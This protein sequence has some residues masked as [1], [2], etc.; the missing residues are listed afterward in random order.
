MKI[1]IPNFIRWYPVTSILLSG[2]LIAFSI[3]TYNYLNINYFNVETHIPV[4]VSGVHH[5]GSE[6]LISHFSVNK[7]IGDNISRS[8]SSGIVCC[9]MIPKKWSPGLTA[10]V[11]W[12]VLHVI[13]QPDGIQVA[14]EELV[15]IYRAQV[16]V[17]AYSEGDRFWVHFFPEGRVRIVVNS[18]APEAEQHPIRWGDPDAS[19]KATVGA[20]V[21]TF[22]TAEE[23]ADL[24][25]RIE[26]DKKKYGDWR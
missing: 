2:I 22:Y 5:M 18:F 16:P 6:Y 10:D 20:V 24:E 15:A 14:R 8:G 21:D 23:M 9:L 17:E 25:R 13:L 12:E 1:P 3:F 4:T 26:R 11:R 19:K 7:E